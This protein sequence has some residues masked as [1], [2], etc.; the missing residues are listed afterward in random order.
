M[1]RQVRRLCGLRGLFVVTSFL[2]ISTWLLFSVLTPQAP[3][4]EQI[5]RELWINTSK[6]WL[7]RQVCRWLALCGLQN[8]RPDPARIAEPAE[9]N[10]GEDSGDLPIFLND[11]GCGLDGW[12]IPGEQG[13]VNNESIQ[14][15]LRDIP[16]YVLERAPLVHLDLE[17]NFWPA[18]LAEHVRHMTPAA[19]GKPISLPGQL[20]LGNIHQLNEKRYGNVALTSK[21][22]VETRPEWLYSHIGIPASS[23]SSYSSPTNRASDMKS[24]KSNRPS[25]RPSRKQT[26]AQQCPNSTNSHGF[27]HAPAVLILVEKESGILD[28]FWFFFFSYN[29]GKSVLWGP[30]LE[31]H[32]GDLEYAMIRFNHS[33]PVAAFLSQHRSGQGY[34]FDALEKRGKRP[35]FYCAQGSHGLY[36]S[37]GDH[38]FGLPFGLLKD[39]TSSGPLWDVRKN[40]YAYFYDFLAKGT[41]DASEEE[42]HFVPAA[43]NPDAP[44]SWL[45][46]N[47]LWGDA[48]YSLGDERQW[49]VSSFFHHADGPAGPKFKYLARARLC[50]GDEECI[51]SN[52]L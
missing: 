9:E 51:I 11:N 2:L 44:T 48:P 18:D 6:Y 25:L 5:E 42:D 19:D 17:E 49:G 41:A 30:R 22:P 26:R 40:I 23:G 32:V 45:H 16:D 27:S 10:D 21:D 7:D 50:P 1:M 46:Y 37:P 38:P 3:T 28:A 8:I 13:S 14:R 33:I 4:R 39:V 15:V 24:L 35:V 31:N 52:K 29:F 36:P 20:H 43:S 12:E 47:G 34:T